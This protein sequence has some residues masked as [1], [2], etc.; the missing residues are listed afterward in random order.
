MLAP[1]IQTLESLLAEIRACR[2]C[3]KHIEPRPVLRA[4][5]TAR[6]LIAGQAPGTRVHE[7]GIPYDDPSGNRLREWMGIGPGIFYDERRVA[8][9]PMGFCFPGQDDNGAD[10]P[11]RPECAKL[12]HA[13]L[14]EQ[15]PRFALSL[16]VGSYSQR[17]HLGGRAK[18]SLT[19][20][21]A[22]WRDYTPKAIPLPHPSWRNNAWLKKNPWFEKELL[23]YLRRAVSRAL[24]R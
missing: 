21:V 13:R 3:E 17:W 6:I 18:P 15:L 4:S 23:P 7:S 1:K 2:V 19:E 9:V 8:I 22:A 16:Y 20:T 24:S 10:L 14:M 11:P 12:W 5:L